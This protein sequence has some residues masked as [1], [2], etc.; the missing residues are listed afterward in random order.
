MVKTTPH[1]LVPIFIDQQK[2]ELE[3]GV[4]TAAQLL[5]LAG[6][7]PAETT[8]VIRIGNDLDQLA[9]E[10]SFEPKPGSHFVVFHCAPTPVS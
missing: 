2:F 6:E 5:E 8:L 3:P 4:Y 7:N 9:D 1:K 10:E